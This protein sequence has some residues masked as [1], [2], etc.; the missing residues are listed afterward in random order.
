MP[1]KKENEKTPNFSQVW[2]L[3]NLLLKKSII[4]VLRKLNIKVQ[5]MEKKKYLSVH[6]TSGPVFSLFT[7]LL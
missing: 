2:L 3:L 4:L 6:E 1:T 5:H 7:L